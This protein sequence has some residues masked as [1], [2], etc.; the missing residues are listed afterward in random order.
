M[1]FEGL[2]ATSTKIQFAVHIHILV[3]LLGGNDKAKQYGG[4]AMEI[5]SIHQSCVDCRFKHVPLYLVVP[6]FICQIIMVLNLI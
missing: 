4:F 1:I 5:G 2:R 6:V 3:N